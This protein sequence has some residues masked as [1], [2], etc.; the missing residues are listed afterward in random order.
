[1]SNFGRPVIDLVGKRFGR[2][3]VIRRAVNRKTHQA[4]WH[5]QCDCGNF[6]IV[7]GYLLRSGRTKSCGCWKSD[8]ASKVYTKLGKLRSKH[9][10][11]PIR[12]YQSWR[13]MKQR[14]FNP[15]NPYFDDYGGRG[16]SVCDEWK[17]DFISFRDWSLSN[18]YEET[19]TIDRI[20]NDGDYTPENCR[21]VH[22]SVQANNRRSTRLISYN[23]ETHSVTEWAR[24]CN[25]PAPILFSRLKRNTFEEAISKPY[26]SYKSKAQEY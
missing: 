12:L 1:M 6:S 5:C 20:D 11:E 25:I 18:G 9:G 8:I 26:N 13:N 14:C 4:R 21:W 3:L 23:G 7:F 2:L 10:K 24:I 22:I 17:H 15:A 16:I 19:L